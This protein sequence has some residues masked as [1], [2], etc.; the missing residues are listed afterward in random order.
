MIVVS[1]T[2]PLRYLTLLGM[3]DLLPRLFTKSI[4]QT[5]LSA[6]AFTLMP[7]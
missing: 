7:L 6:S 1:D 2:T 5:R 4:A 3:Q